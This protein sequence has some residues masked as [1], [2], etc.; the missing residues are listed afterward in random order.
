MNIKVQICGLAIVLLLYIFYKSHRTLK[1]YRE[2]I[3]KNAMFSCMCCLT[4]DIASLSAILYRKTLPLAVVNG[5]CKTYINL[6]VWSTMFAFVYVFVDIMAT[7]EDRG[8]MRFYLIGTL[9]SL[10]VYFLPIYIHDAAD[11]VYT[12]GPSVTLVYVFCMINIISTLLATFL[13]ASRINPRRKFAVR[14]WMCIWILSAVV[15]FF[16]SALLL[17]GFA[18]ALGVLILFV[19][20]ENPEANI[21]RRFECFNSY[22]LNEYLTK[23]LVEKEEQSAVE[24]SYQLKIEEWKLDIEAIMTKTLQALNQYGSVYV[25]KNVNMDLVLLSDEKEQL[26]EASK[27]ALRIFKKLTGLEHEITPILTERIGQFKEAEEL[28]RFWSYVRNEYIERKGEIFLVTDEIIDS[29]IRYDLVK[30]EIE[31]ALSE[32]RVEVFFQPIYSNRAERFT[33]AEALVRIRKKDGSLLSPAVFIPVAEDTGQI[34]RLGERVF[35]KVCYFLKNTDILQKGISYVEVNL[36]VIQFE[37]ENLAEQLINILERFEARAEWI[38]LEITETA[39]I[40]AKQTLLEN[41]KKLIEYGFHFSLDDFGKG[42]SNLMYVVEMPVSLIKFDYDMSKAF[43]QSDKA[44]HVVRAVVQMAHDM[45][46]RIVAEGI[47]TKEELDA[48]RNES[49]DYIQGFYYSGPLPMQEFLEFC[50][51]Q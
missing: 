13:Y 51:R 12:Y 11:G 7:R 30:Q 38:N 1:L 31:D 40:S 8:L 5:I 33:S 43:F 26:E 41:M 36:S 16:N 18:G 34:L 29:Y 23:L 35:E 14:L 15:Q 27:E 46:L 4:L 44:R 50:S 10:I 42:E 39:S 48:M 21:D 22:A 3:F 45:E 20:M 28:F 24:I 2:K 9:E 25:F 37:K 19:L 17:V 47:E 32:D 6:L 49:I